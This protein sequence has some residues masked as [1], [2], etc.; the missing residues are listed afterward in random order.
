MYRWI[1]ATKARKPYAM[2]EMGTPKSAANTSAEMYGLER[3][4]ATGSIRAGDAAGSLMPG[5]PARQ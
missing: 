1:V 4:T 3:I 5:N 2:A